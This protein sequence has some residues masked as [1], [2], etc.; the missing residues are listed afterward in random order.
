MSAKIIWTIIQE[1]NKF[2]MSLGNVYQRIFQGFDLEEVEREE[3]E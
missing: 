2:R 1:V 3:T